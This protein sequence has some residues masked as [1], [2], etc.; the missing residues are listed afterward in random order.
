[1]KT[2]DRERHSPGQE[3]PELAPIRG[4]GDSGTL[5]KPAPRSGQGRKE[6]MPFDY[7]IREKR[8]KSK[9]QIEGQIV[10]QNSPMPKQKI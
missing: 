8:K 5:C 10:T 9:E 7:S 1:M 4:R 3:C 2:G 6:N